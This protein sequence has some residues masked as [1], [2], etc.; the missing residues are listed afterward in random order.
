MHIDVKVTPVPKDERTDK[1][2]YDVE[3]KTYNG[4]I[5]GRFE[6][7]ELRHLI[8]RIDNAIY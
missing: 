6:H 7:F 5:T 4:K 1:N 8:Q 2:Q 3:L